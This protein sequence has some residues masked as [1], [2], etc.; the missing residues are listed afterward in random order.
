MAKPNTSKKERIRKKYDLLRS[1][2]G[3]DGDFTF[4]MTLPNERYCRE[5]ATLLR[6]IADD[7]DVDHKEW[8]FKTRISERVKTDTGENLF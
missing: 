7:M 3:K 2:D 6:N 4:L 5:V 8:F 1:T